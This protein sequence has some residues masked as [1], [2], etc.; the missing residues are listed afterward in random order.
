MVAFHRIKSS[1]FLDFSSPFPFNQGPRGLFPFL[2]SLSAALS[3]P[4]ASEWWG[5]SLAGPVVF[6]T[7]GF[8]YNTHNCC[9]LC[10]F[11]PHSTLCTTFPPAT[12]IV[13]SSRLPPPSRV[14]SRVS[15]SKIPPT[16]PGT[17]TTA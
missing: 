4:A 5:W 17:Y 8:T 2:C 10:N 15:D 3:S 12:T 1:S 7:F 11:L 16:L 13:G 9:L 6:L 14:C